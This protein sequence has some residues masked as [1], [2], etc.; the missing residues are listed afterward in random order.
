M[1]AIVSISEAQ[2]R[3]INKERSKLLR[4]IVNEAGAR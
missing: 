3:R 1:A 4:I 2:W